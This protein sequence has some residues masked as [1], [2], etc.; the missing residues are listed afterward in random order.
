MKVWQVYGEGQGFVI[1][2]IEMA[3]ELSGLVQAEDANAAFSRACELAVRDHPELAQAAGPF[4]RPAINPLEIQEVGEA[5]AVEVGKVQLDW[6][7]V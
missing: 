5:S 2:G 3:F 7:Q 1:D 6:L 4:P